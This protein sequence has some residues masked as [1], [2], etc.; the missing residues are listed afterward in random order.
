M[1]TICLSLRTLNVAQAAQGTSKGAA[2]SQKSA[3]ELS[4]MATELQKLVSNFNM[5]DDRTTPLVESVPLEKNLSDD[6]LSAEQELP[7]IPREKWSLEP[8]KKAKSQVTKMLKKTPD[9]NEHDH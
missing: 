5:K 3:E 8:Y 6:N 1:R 9:S 7:D 4:F 2:S